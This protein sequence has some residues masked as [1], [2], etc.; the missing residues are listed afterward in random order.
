MSYLGKEKE[1]S[2]AVFCITYYSCNLV[3]ALRSGALV[4]LRGEPIGGHQ[5]II[6]L[7]RY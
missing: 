6:T 7:I 1:W 4:P 5:G 2:Y 3:L